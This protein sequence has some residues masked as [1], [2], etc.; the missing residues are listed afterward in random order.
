M[1]VSVDSAL[2]RDFCGRAGGS[3]IRFPA[4]FSNCGWDCLFLYI[5]MNGTDMF[6]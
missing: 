1:P 2:F 6:E 4:D 5:E 3:F